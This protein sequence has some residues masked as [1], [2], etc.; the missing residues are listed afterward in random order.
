MAQR[1][2]P[3]LSLNVPSR[4]LEAVDLVVGSPASNFFFSLVGCPRCKR[5]CKCQGHALSRAKG[6]E[7]CGTPD[8]LCGG[9]P[10][11]KAGGN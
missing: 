5:Q 7:A 4:R 10:L 2:R 9:K 11:L 8:L 1:R 6:P 3:A